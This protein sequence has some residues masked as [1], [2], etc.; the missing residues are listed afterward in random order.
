[1]QAKCLEEKKVG[2]EETVTISGPESGS[3]QVEVV[4]RSG[5]KVLRTKRGN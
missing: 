3:F 2:Y 5:L 4:R 1:V